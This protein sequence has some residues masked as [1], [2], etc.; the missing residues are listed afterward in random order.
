M[1][2]RTLMEWCLAGWL[3]L[4]GSARAATP[5]TT[6]NQV[7][8]Q[9]TVV[10]QVGNDRGRMT[11]VAQFDAD[12]PVAVSRHLDSSMAWALERLRKL[13]DLDRR[14]GDYRVQ[15]VYRKGRLDHWHGEQTLILT[16]P[17]PQAL[18]R[19]AGLLQ[20]RLQ[21]RGLSFFLSS[22]R[23]EALIDDLL[24]EALRRFKARARHISQRL[25]HGRYRIVELAVGGDDRLPPPRP[26]LRMQSLAASS[27]STPALAA[28]KGEV[29]L[30]LTGVI[31]FE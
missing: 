10:R 25:G 17:H 28:G 21:I 16:S 20:S 7:R 14:T 27:L 24:D 19:V 5:P 30:T 13:P 22:A 1:Q 26:L 23:R 4:A 6:Y 2:V 31:Q 8:Y 18:A 3:V 9:V 29:R 15:P 12:D 11:L